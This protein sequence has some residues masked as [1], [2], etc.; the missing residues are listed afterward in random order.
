M[1]KMSNYRDRDTGK[2]LLLLICMIGASIIIAWY[3]LKEDIALFSLVVSKLNFRFLDMLHGQGAFGE[4]VIWCLYPERFLSPQSLDDIQQIY[5]TSEPTSMTNMDIYAHLS[6]AGYFI[7]W[8]VLIIGSL[9]LMSIFKSGKVQRRTRRYKNIIEL[10]EYSKQTF[11]H[12][13]PALSQNLLEKNPDI[14]PYRREESP[15]RFAI[16]NGLISAYKLKRKGVIKSGKAQV[17]SITGQ[18]GMYCLK[19]DLTNHISKIHDLCEFNSKKAARVF[20]EQLGRKFTTVDALS[21][22]K[23]AM[24]AVFIAFYCTDFGKER[25]FELLKQF[26]DSWDYRKV[27]DENGEYLSNPKDDYIDTTGIDE[28]INKGIKNEFV[29]KVMSSHAYEDT[30]LCGLLQLARTKGK[31]WSAF[32]YWLLPVNRGLFWVLDAIGGHTSW[33]EASAKYSHFIAESKAET[34]LLIPFIKPAIEGLYFYL[35]E[36]EGWIMSDKSRELYFPSEV[37]E[38]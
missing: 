8:P 29:A 6:F 26:N 17:V 35:D 27:H 1:I 37:E 15:I 20:T 14:G 19:D 10:F 34:P 25:A 21:I 36:T 22:E 28:I 32:W 9:S 16:N 33:T 23:R 4:A 12:L 30:M 11:P 18:S 7:R 3:F 31:L 38:Y 24:L 5:R 13:K 2:E